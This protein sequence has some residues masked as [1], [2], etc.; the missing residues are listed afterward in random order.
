[1][2]KKAVKE[3]FIFLSNLATIVM[4]TEDTKP[5]EDKPKV[6]NEVWVHPD[7]ML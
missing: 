7:P 6:F 2:Q 5:T 1:M 3:N 4:I